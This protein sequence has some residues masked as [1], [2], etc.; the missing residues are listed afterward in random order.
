[1]RLEPGI[2]EDFDRYFP[3]KKINALGVAGEGQ[4]MCDE[5]RETKFSFDDETQ[6]GLG[7]G[8]VV[9]AVAHEQQAGAE[10]VAENA[11]KRNVR[12]IEMESHKFINL[13]EKFIVHVILVLGLLITVTPF[14][15]MLSTSLKSGGGIFTYPPQLFPRNPTLEWYRQLFRGVNFLLHFR[16]SLIVSVTTTVLIGP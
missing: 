15:W 6:R 12:F 5:R 8:A 4:R 1:M 11:Q 13:L 7:G 14:V 2:E 3:A 16:N 9:V 10:E